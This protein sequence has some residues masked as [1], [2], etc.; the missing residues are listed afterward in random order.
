MRIIILSQ[1]YYPEPDT[2]HTLSTGLVKR[3]H[4]VRVITGYPNYPGGKIYSGYSQ[5]LWKNENID[6]VR[7]IRLPLFPDRSRSFIKRSLNYISFP[8]VASLL[9]PILCGKGDAMIVQSPP[10]T[11]GIPAWV[12]KIFRRIP[13]VYMIQDMW[14]E[15]LP[16]TGM[17][18]NKK[19][20]GIISKLGQFAYSQASLISVISPGFR[21]NLIE[22]NIPKEKIHIIYNWAYEVDYSEPE[23]DIDLANDLGMTG[24]F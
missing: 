7:V 12:I 2:M 21:N 19:L 3:G 8:L 15:T 6:G 4:S 17:V 1:N 23:K 16:A 13:F 9:G 10:V 11:L 18:T 5:R 24:Y 20:L 22:K 14:P